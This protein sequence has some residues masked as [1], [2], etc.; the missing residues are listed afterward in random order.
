ME[1]RVIIE[2]IKQRIKEGRFG[3]LGAQREFGLS[4]HQARRFVKIAKQEMQFKQEINFEPKEKIMTKGLTT[5]QLRAKFDN[6]FIVRNT[7]E[8]LEKDIF[9]SEAEF[10]QM[11]NFSNNAGYRNAIDHPQ[12]EKYHGKAGG[13]RYWSHPDSIKQ[14]KEEAVLK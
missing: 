11:C 12:F 13:I 5:E 14:L 10:V 3:R 6:T 1:K 9:L 2:K 8:K 7:A 4:E